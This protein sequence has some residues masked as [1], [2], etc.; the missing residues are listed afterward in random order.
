MKCILCKSEYVGKSESPFN[1][2]LNNQRKYVNYPKAIPVY[3]YFKIYGH[4][5]MK[6]AKST[7]I[8]QLTEI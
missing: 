3:H 5:F 4:K 6:H 2:R 1:L 8:E 7:L